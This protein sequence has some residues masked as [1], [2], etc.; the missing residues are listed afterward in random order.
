M[1]ITLVLSGVDTHSMWWTSLALA[2]ILSLLFVSLVRG[3]EISRKDVVGMKASKGNNKKSQYKQEKL[4]KMLTMITMEPSQLT[5]LQPNGS[6]GNPMH[7]PSMDA[8]FAM[9]HSDFMIRRDAILFAGTLRKTGFKGD[10]VVG[11]SPTAKSDFIQALH[12]LKCIL[13]T[14][15]LDCGDVRN[16]KMCTFKEKTNVVAPIAMIRYFLYEFWATKYESSSWIMLS[17]FSD[18]IFQTNPFQY[19]TEEWKSFQLL[20][21]LEHHP[22]KVINRCIFNR[23]WIESCYGHE[24]IVK[25]GSN[26]VSCSGITMGSRDAI[27]L[28]SHV[29]SQQLNP[30]VRYGLNSTLDNKECFS[31]GM[32][33]GFHNY[34]LYSGQLDAYMDIKWYAQG[35]GPVNTIGALKN[36]IMMYNLDMWKA[37]V[38]RGT[39]LGIGNITIHNY[40]GDLS[41]AIHQYDRFEGRLFDPNVFD[42]LKMIYRLGAQDM[43]VLFKDL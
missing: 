42:T 29:M 9:G 11:V 37:G 19:R 15:N 3:A 43:K 23:G 36:A 28:Y 38:L 6:F 10:I 33:Q 21:F 2:T 39:G 41:P 20:V 14:I 4:L 12:D 17:D 16:S 24:A 7:Q 30:L 31:I 26:T 13:Y 18:V 27:M 22:T 34:L 35:E 32:D 8:V 1:K 25:Y 5:F 40:N